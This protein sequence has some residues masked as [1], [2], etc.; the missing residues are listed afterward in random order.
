[1]PTDMKLF[2]SYPESFPNLALV[3]SEKTSDGLD[4]KLGR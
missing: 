4:T 2:R 1:M 3:Q